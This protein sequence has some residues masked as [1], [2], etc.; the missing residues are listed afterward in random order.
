MYFVWDQKDDRG[1]RCGLNRI[2][3]GMFR[4]PTGMASVQKVGCT[5]FRA[6]WYVWCSSKPSMMLV[7]HAFNV[8]AATASNDLPTL[9]P[10]AI[11]DGQHAKKLYG[12]V[13]TLK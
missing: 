2:C 1:V 3:T 11:M 9:P 7:V 8:F 12:L 13:W 4:F 10:T 6:L 5:F